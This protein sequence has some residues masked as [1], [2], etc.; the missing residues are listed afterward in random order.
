MEAEI[1]DKEKEIVYQIGKVKRDLKN[2]Y[3][4]NENLLVWVIPKE[5]ACA[6]RPLRYH[7]LYGESGKRLLPD[8]THDVVDWAETISLLGIK[9]VICFM[10]QKEIDYYKDL[11]LDALNLIEFYK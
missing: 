4:H 10:H 8:A 5:L 9:S 11:D 1:S 7:P 3:K 6:H 2:N